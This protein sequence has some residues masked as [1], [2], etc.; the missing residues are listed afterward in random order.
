MIDIATLNANS[1]FKAQHTEFSTGITNA[2]QH[3]LAELSKEL[4]TPHMKGR[5]EGTPNLPTYIIEAMGRCGV[6]KAANQKKERS[7]EGQ[8]KRKRLPDVLNKQREQSSQ[9]LLEM[10]Y[11]SVQWSQPK[12]NSL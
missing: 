1:F 8:Q 11:P 12:A 4:V 9:L 2:R 6:T 3:F 7:T 5:L 10:Q